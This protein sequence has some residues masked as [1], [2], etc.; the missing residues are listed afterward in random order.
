MVASRSIPKSTISHSMPSLTYSSCSSTNLN[1]HRNWYHTNCLKDLFI[2]TYD[3]WRIVGAFRYRSWYRFVQ[4]YWTQKSQILKR[5]DLINL[6]GNK[7]PKLEI[8]NFEYSLKGL[9]HLKRGNWNI[10]NQR[11]RESQWSWPFSWWGQWAFCCRD[12]QARQTSCCRSTLPGQR[13]HWGTGLR[14]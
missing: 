5:K 10:S 9:G 4:T 8:K 11:C 12:Q 6:H 14:V 1:K 13:W 7:L 2:V 3:G